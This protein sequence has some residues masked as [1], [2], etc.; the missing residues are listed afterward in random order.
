MKYVVYA[1]IYRNGELLFKREPITDN[2]V[3][4]GSPISACTEA[5]E[6]MLSRRFFDY[7]YEDENEE[8][9][10][11]IC[12]EYYELDGEH[13]IETY[14]NFETEEVDDDYTVPMPT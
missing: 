3:E 14:K 4:A 8:P 12:L 10:T 5:V 6:F 1:D 11:S 9:H 7:S 2:P 13:V